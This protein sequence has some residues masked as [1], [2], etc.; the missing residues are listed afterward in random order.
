MSAQ[1]K[2][3]KLVL[4]PKLEKVYR[5][6]VRLIGGPFAL[7]KGQRKPLCVIDV[8][9]EQTLDDL[10]KAIFDAFERYDM[11]LYEF[12]IGG[13]APMDLTSVR[14][15][16]PEDDR[17]DEKN[18]ERTRIS[19]LDL[20][21]GETFFYW[22]DFA[23]DWMHEI[24]LDAILAAE[25]GEHYPKLVKKQGA[26]PPQYPDSEME[27]NEEEGINTFAPEDIGNPEK[28]KSA[29]QSILHPAKPKHDLG[30]LTDIF[31]KTA[32][33]CVEHLDHEYANV[34][35]ALLL[36]I[37]QDSD[38]PLNHG[39]LSDWAAALV[40]VA[41][42][43]N[44]LDD[45]DSE[46]FMKLADIAQYLGVSKCAMENRS[47]KIRKALKIERLAPDFC[48]LSVLAAN[49]QIWILQNEKGF[50]F[51]VRQTPRKVQEQAFAAGLIPWIPADFPDLHKEPTPSPKRQSGKRDAS[52]KALKKED[53]SQDQGSLFDALPNKGK[54][55]T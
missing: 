53:P 5:F 51:D 52:K 7:K 32:D 1:F 6:T 24:R 54:D 34:C 48:T 18:A 13:K 20:A 26:S 23:D 25:E 47:R 2:S 45:P 55:K 21:I 9:D 17:E 49:P 50:F 44:F 42:F 22:F 41:G 38:L 43:V 10:H 16:L 46:P 28:V 37:D 12:Q 39:T 15:G 19:S 8:R 29:I 30:L 31:I 3:P 11:H 4:L 40:H 27:E 36:L 33:F 35:L 14:Y